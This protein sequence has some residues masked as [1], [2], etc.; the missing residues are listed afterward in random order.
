MGYRR[1]AFGGIL[2]ARFTL[3]AQKQAEA[4]LIACRIK[5]ITQE[6][7]ANVPGKKNASDN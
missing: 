5:S 1:T 7:I 6:L 2:Y 4:N 3:T